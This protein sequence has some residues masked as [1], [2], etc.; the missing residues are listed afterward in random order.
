MKLKLQE[1]IVETRS[2]RIGKQ[3]RPS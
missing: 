1:K 3:S 2:F